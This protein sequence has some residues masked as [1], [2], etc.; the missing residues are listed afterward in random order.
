M[1]DMTD[2]KFGGWYDAYTGFPVITMVAEGAIAKFH[3]V[4]LGTAGRQVKSYDGDAGVTEPAIGIALEAAATG[5]EVVI[6]PL[7]P[8]IRML[9]GTNGVTRGDWVVPDT[10]AAEDGYVM[11][12]DGAMGTTK[13][14]AIGIAL[15]TGD[16]KEEL[17]PVMVCGNGIFGTD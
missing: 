17:V 12:D 15:E 8:V 16:V 6:L 7:G 14:A 2:S 1:A 13:N 10:T 11:S 4:Q 5:L 9:T 3:L